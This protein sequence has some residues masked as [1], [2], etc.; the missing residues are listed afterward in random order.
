MRYAT[1]GGGGSHVPEY[2]PER[3]PF[4]DIWSTNGIR[5]EQVKYLTTVERTKVG[6]YSDWKSCGAFLI[7]R[8][9][10]TTENYG[11]HDD[12]VRQFTVT[13]VGFYD[14]PSNDWFQATARRYLGDLMDRSE[15]EH[16]P[17]DSRTLPARPESPI[18]PP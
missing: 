4:K 3:F 18:L 5:S 2:E 11:F 8:R 6:E 16:Q 14:S 9:F 1:Q 17:G 15:S 12:L 7:P 13:S 10:V